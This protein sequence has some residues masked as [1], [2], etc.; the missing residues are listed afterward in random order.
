[1]PFPNTESRSESFPPYNHH[2]CSSRA[3]HGLSGLRSSSTVVFIVLACGYVTSLLRGMVSSE[4]SSPQVGLFRSPLPTAALP[5]RQGLGAWSEEYSFSGPHHRITP[6]AT[7]LGSTKPCCCVW[8]PLASSHPGFVSM[9]CILLPH[10]TPKNLLLGINSMPARH[11][12][13]VFK[14]PVRGNH[15]PSSSSQTT[16]PTYPHHTTIVWSQ[17]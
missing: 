14:V 10:P 3:R 15:M 6:L 12:P 16:P 11:P 5:E 2:A 8:L 13:E 1:M 4:G 17:V 7:D 9:P